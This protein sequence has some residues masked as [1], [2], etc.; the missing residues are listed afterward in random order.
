MN[1]HQEATGL[2]VRKQKHKEMVRSER[3]VLF[4]IRG[5]K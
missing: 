4:L 5:G 2:G 1:N 3:Q